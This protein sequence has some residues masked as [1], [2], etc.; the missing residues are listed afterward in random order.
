MSVQTFS[1]NYCK[2]PIL[3]QA[4][5]LLL[6]LEF[7]L[8]FVAIPSA[9]FLKLVSLPIMSILAAA[10]LTASA[11]LISDSQFEAANLINLKFERKHLWK[12]L[13]RFLL[14]VP[15][16]IL[17]A[18]V[19]IPQELISSLNQE[20]PVWIGGAVVYILFSVLPQEIIFRAFF[21]H[22]YKDLFPGRWLLILVSTA[23]FAFIHIIY[24]N[25]VA[26][27]LTI[28]GGY[29]FSKTYYETGSFLLTVIEHSLYGCFL[30]TI[31]LGA[32]FFMN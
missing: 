28:V 3:P 1:G 12:I 26:I 16:I 13:R 22:R 32:A 14:S 24:F 17:L 11:L 29:F 27:A 5:R 9:L 30:F 18:S 19:L 8:V 25:T 7:I 23:S 21:F 6:A 10:C 15:L 31:G 2:T 4:K 20:F